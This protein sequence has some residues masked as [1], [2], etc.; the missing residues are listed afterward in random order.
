MDEAARRVNPVPLRALLRCRELREENALRA[1]RGAAAERLRAEEAEEEA[2]RLAEEHEVMRHAREAGLLEKM[3]N[4]LQT[5][6]KILNTREHLERLSEHA[7][8]LAE[9]RADAGQIKLDAEA[10]LED[11]K[12]EHRRRI[13]ARQKWARTLDRVQDARSEYQA[14]TEEAELEDETADRFGANLNARDHG[15]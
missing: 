14:A 15:R 8:L 4:K 2:V 9:E 1:V 11:A 5:A 6:D 7:V 12:D 10:A 13:R 3:R